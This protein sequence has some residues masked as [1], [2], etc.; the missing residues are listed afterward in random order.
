M[1]VLNSN[2]SGTWASVIA[3][4]DHAA[5][6]CPAVGKCVANMSLGGG[7]SASLNKAVDDAVTAGVMMVVAAGNDGGDACT[8]SPASA[9]KAITIGSIDSNDSMST[10]SNFGECVDLYEPGSFIKSA[11]ST[12]NTATNTISGTS[13][14]SPRKCTP[15]TQ[16][17]SHILCCGSSRF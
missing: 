5:T 15:H 7:L 10:F 4:I 16:V 1:K 17:I 9:E 8:K 14:A 3:G 2:G 11:W 13:M 12:S 6:D